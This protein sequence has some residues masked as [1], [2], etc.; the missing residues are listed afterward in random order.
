VIFVQPGTY[1]ENID[2]KGKRLILQG[3]TGPVPTV[4]DGG[5]GAGPVVS[6]GPGANATVQGLTIQNGGGIEVLS[7]A[8]II[9]LNRIVG[10]AGIT[11]GGIT[12][13]T[14]SPLIKENEILNN[15][16]EIGGAGIHLVTCSPIIE[17]NIISGNASVDGGGGIHCDTSSPIIRE[18]EIRG[19]TSLGVG[20][21]G[22][23]LEVS[24]PIIKLNTISYNSAPGPGMGL[25][26]GIYMEASSPVIRENVIE[27]NHGQD[28]GGI[29]VL[30]GDPL[31]ERNRIL[32][33][34]AARSGAG[35][36]VNVN[37][38][39]AIYNNVIALNS[40]A[41]KG[42]G[43]ACQDSVGF[44]ITNNTLS[45][46][47]AGT[48]GGGIY[49]RA[50]SPNISN[51][52][53]SQSTS[54]EGIFCELGSEP[55]LS[56]NDFWANSGGEFG[57][58]CGLGP[59]DISVDPVFEACGL[60]FH[61]T[62]G[63]GV[64]D[65]GLNTV[66][67]M[68]S[69]DMDEDV[70]VLD[71]NS[72]FVATVDIGADEYTCHDT[73]RDGFTNC[74]G[75]CDD[76]EPGIHPL[77]SEICDGQDNNCNCSSDE[78]FDPDG[79]SIGDECGDNC[80]GV[81]NPD[82]KDSGSVGDPN[83][84]GIGDACQAGDVSGDGVVDGLDVRQMREEQ[85]GLLAELDA[86]ENCSVDGDAECNMVDVVILQRALAGIEPQLSGLLNQTSDP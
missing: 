26:G 19:N 45:E 37:A 24:A 76:T 44:N 46:N 86:P 4:L 35:I 58:S 50:S 21:G 82:Q 29:F 27:W 71:G 13:I 70:R 72:D 11:G 52:I 55:L 49:L 25:G 38:T 74:A 33:N 79:D 17:S 75:D 32:S 5:G 31:I 54:G 57:G 83:P 53:V 41:V 30:G 60:D 62:E 66:P 3:S 68:P 6:I 78:G 61:L 73:D 43:I 77:A 69:R 18:N 22:I 2:L 12:C 51:N 34:T 39:P 65:A 28:G 64:I 40:A 48:R 14:G 23:H 63:S 36:S 84:D 42:G 9:R 81:F 15:A 67:E 16:S 7:A 20:G 56:F 85:A 47:S 8:P 10:N 80:P 1:V 59:D